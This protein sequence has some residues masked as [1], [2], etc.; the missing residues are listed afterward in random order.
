MIIKKNSILLNTVIGDALGRSLDGFGRD[1][2][3]ASLKQINRF[4]EIEQLLKHK[5]E[6]WKKS[7]LYSSISQLMLITAMCFKRGRFD[8][9][10]FFLILSK[11]P[12]IEDSEFGIF[13]NPGHVEKTI[14]ITAQSTAERPRVPAFGSARLIP[15]VV[16]FVCFKKP[17]ELLKTIVIFI[18]LFT[19]DTDTIAAACIFAGIMESLINDESSQLHHI[20]DVAIDTTEKLHHDAVNKPGEIFNAGV[21]PDSL[22]DAYAFYKNVFTAI[23]SAQSKEKA[24]QII[25]AMAHKSL[26]TPVTRGTVDICRV[27][28]PYLLYLI[29]SNAHSPSDMMFTIAIE[30]GAVSP[31][32]AMTGSILAS[33]YGI[34]HTPKTLL[35]NLVNKKKLC[36]LIDSINDITPPEAVIDNFLLQEKMLTLKEHEE[37]QAQLKHRKKASPQKKS[38]KKIESAISGHIVESWTKLD[39]AK[40]KKEKRKWKEN[41][42]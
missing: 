37:F 24:E 22:L 40:W 23:A 11:N 2:I 32:L 39:R 35:D 8:A 17:G 21:N 30:G 38:R 7:G 9:E 6:K 31:M 14:I 13:R 20:V 36:Q 41:E 33:L 34:D 18:R 19:S 10:H 28:F 12:G 4:P 15:L 27:L 16:P 1:H 25:C 42:S 3:K 26:K 29:T 5:I